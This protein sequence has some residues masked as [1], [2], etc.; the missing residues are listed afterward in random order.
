[1]YGVSFLAVSFSAVALKIKL[2]KRKPIAKTKT[3]ITIM[4]NNSDKNG[5]PFVIKTSHHQ[6][7]SKPLFLL[8]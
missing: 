4:K 8:V 3:P 7:T 6:A 1:M 5:N 2:K